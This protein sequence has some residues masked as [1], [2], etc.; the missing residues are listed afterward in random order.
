MICVFCTDDLAQSFSIDAIFILC[1]LYVKVLVSDLASIQTCSTILQYCSE[2][3]VVF[4]TDGHN[5][6]IHTEGHRHL[7]AVNTGCIYNED[8]ILQSVA[9]IMKTY[10]AG[11]AFSL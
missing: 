2:M 8:C 3:L 9:A 4:T 1:L 5:T 6:F 10:K 7:H 11:T